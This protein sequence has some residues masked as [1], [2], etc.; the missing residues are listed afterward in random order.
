MA[1]PSS[2]TLTDAE[3]RLMQIL[4]H[5]G[6]STV[7]EVVA[8]LPA[9]Q[10]LAYSTVLTTLRILEKKGYLRHERRGRAYVYHTLVAQREARGKALRHLMRR[11][12]DDSPEQLVLGVLQHEQLG[13]DDLAR[14]Q[15]LLTDH[16]DDT[17]EDDA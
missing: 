5:R 4:W 2:S 1:R 17:P 3:L 16:G 8:A 12:F 15:Q 10:P 6:P 7:G 14:L 11:F 9:D 13:A